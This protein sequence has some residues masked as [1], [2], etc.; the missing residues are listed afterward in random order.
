MVVQPQTSGTNLLLVFCSLHFIYV[1]YCPYI[2]NNKHNDYGHF[3]AKTIPALAT[4]SDTQT[5]LAARLR[6]IRLQSRFKR[7]TLAQMS[8]VSVSSLRRFETTGEIS[9]KSLLRLAQALGRL[10]EFTALL[11]PLPA[12]SLEELEGRSSSRPPRRGRI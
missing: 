6:A 3:M 5:L 11:A 9:L 10:P 1:Y 4:P 12:G 7:A 8:G 2:D